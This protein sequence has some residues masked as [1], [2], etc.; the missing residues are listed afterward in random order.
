MAEASVTTPVASLWDNT[1][2]CQG[3]SRARR[4]NRGPSGG[5]KQLV[6]PT[7]VI[8]PMPGPGRPLPLFSVPI[9]QATPSS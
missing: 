7:V 8:E 9:F 2:K 3:R 1:F 4:V 5:S 6:K